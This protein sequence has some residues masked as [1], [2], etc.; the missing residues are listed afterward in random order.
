MSSTAGVT[1]IDTKKS[2]P[3]GTGPTSFG[4]PM[5]IGSNATS[6]PFRDPAHIQSLTSNIRSTPNI[7]MKGY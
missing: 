4:V 5:M 7:N 6:R 2:D 3:N 1:H